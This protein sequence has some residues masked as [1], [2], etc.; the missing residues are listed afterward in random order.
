MLDDV[1]YERADTWAHRI[2][3]IGNPFPCTNFF[4]KA[5]Q[6][7]DIPDPYEPGRYNRKIIHISGDDSPNVRRAKYL[8]R[9]K[10]KITHKKL[11]ESSELIPGVLSYQEYERRV[12]LWDEVRKCIG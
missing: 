7:G 5:V 10:P 6:E 12:R 1:H 3:V 4:K 11:V 2:L 9:V 8:K